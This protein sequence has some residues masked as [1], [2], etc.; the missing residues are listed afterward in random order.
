ML[1]GGIVLDEEQKPVDFRTFLLPT[2]N[3][4]IDDVWGL[5]GTGSNDIVV[6]GAFVPEHWSLS[7]TN[8]TRCATR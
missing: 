6:D 4:V 5:R 2:S 7:F 3:Y 1:L 8:V